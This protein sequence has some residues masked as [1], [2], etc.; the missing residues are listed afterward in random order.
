[1]T[2]HLDLTK[3]YQEGNEDRRDTEKMT[4]GQRKPEVRCVRYTSGTSHGETQALGSVTTD[5]AVS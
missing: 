2:W 1:M 4:D 3:G 5:S